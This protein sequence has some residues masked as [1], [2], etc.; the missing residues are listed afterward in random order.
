MP[1]SP[2]ANRFDPYRNFKFKVMFDTK[3]VAGVSKISG[4]KRTTEV[5]K[6]RCG[7]DESSSFK[8][9]GRT[10]YEPI[11][12][13]RGVTQD[14]DFDQWAN[15]CWDYRNAQTQFATNEVSADFRKDII[16]EVLNE[17]GQKV[18]YYTVHQCW[19]SE[20]QALPDLDA[21]ANAVAIQHIKIENEGWVREE[22][23]PDP[24]STFDGST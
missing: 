18:I 16:I 14:P 22:F 9:P 23:T 7:L 15:K 19:V 2:T 20:Y 21:N 12:F 3:Y 4:L 1:P 17:S 11:T 6:H 24:E 10:E 8:L 13:E 5:V